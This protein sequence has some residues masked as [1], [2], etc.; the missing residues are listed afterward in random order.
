MSCEIEK[1]TI[2]AAEQMAGKLDLPEGV[3]PLISFY[4]Y[5]SGSCNLAC[6]HCWIE[7]TVQSGE[8]GGEHVKI[9]YV[10]KVIQEAKPLGLSSVK[11]TGGEPLLHPQF[12]EI[13]NLLKDAKLKIQIE[14]N[15]TLIDAKLAEF[16]KRSG[17]V[18]DISVSLDGADARTHEAMRGIKGCF[19][20][21]VEGIK[22]LVAKNFRPQLICTLH[23]GNVSQLESVIELG[24]N[25]GCGSIKFNHVQEIGRG[26]ESFPK[27]QRLSVSEI[28]NLHRLIESDLANKYKVPLFID[29][30]FAFFPIRELLNGT[31]ARCSVKTMLCML[32]GGELSMCGIGCT[33]PELIYGHIEADNLS[34][35]W[36][37]HPVLLRL[38]EQIPGKMEGICGEC[39]HRFLCLGSC[40]A[41]NYFLTG[42]FNAPYQFCDV[43]EKLGLFPDSRKE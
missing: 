27:S 18:S 9:E 36:F 10:E 23:K 19:D 12:R 22:N 15:G 33:V 11:L 1:T 41:K 39:V 40:V 37:S 16:L 25:L 13:I 4:L 3:P 24:M 21:A 17:H 34:D 28:I 2:Q 38:R 14:T 6:R 43:A 42:K 26:G 30:P 35:I 8:N 32:A 29:I 5:L 31:L 20:L 7:P